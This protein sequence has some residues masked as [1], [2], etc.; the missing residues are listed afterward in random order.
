MAVTAKQTTIITA[1]QIMSS[2]NLDDNQ[3]DEATIQQL[4][5][6]AIAYTEQTVSGNLTID[7][8]ALRTN[9]A[10]VNTLLSTIVTNLFYD[11]YLLESQGF[12]I[13]VKVMLNNIRNI[14]SGNV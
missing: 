8:I 6:F 1:K 12:S 11:R 14:M 7:A 9:Y 2:L 5:D 13:G 4:L 10:L 3:Q